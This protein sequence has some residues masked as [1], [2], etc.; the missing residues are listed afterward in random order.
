MN[1]RTVRFSAVGD[2]SIGD[3]PLCVGFGGFSKLRNRHPAFPFEHVKR[4]FADSD[5]VFGN[6]E[7]TLSEANRNPDDYSSIQM[8]GHPRFCAGL[9]DAG[10]DIVNLANNHSMQHGSESFHETVEMLSK[11]GIHTTG[12]GLDNHLVGIP[13][14]VTKHGLK[15]AFL[16]YSLRPRQYFDHAPE[17]TEGHS[18][19]MVED[20]ERIRDDV[21][22]VIMSVHWGDEFIQ[23]PSPD[24]IVLGR[25]L[26]DAGAN[27]VIGHHPH[28]LRG[29][30]KYNGGYIA[31][32]LGNFVCDMIWDP[33]LR[34]TAVLQCELSKDGVHNVEFTPCYI[35]DDYQPTVLEG[36]QAKA[37]LDKLSR[38]SR[39][40]E[41]ESLSDIDAKRSSYTRAADNEHRYI[42]TKGHRYFLRKIHHY[43]LSI[44]LQQ[45][46]RFFLNRLQEL[47]HGRGSKETT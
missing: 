16:G 40:V 45:L 28:V 27:L 21:D 6:L 22:L 18:K 10:F 38:L 33:T 8:R 35:N 30:E 13:S 41:N 7:C 47:T 37:L 5:L 42:R 36:R 11:H 17:Y 1:D 25:E 3:H 19:G 43:P 34:E 24:E 14:I 31:Y 15:I 39:A 44:L 32:S 20:I 4:V 9:V 23:R 29:V 46:K 2:V 12:V 26:I